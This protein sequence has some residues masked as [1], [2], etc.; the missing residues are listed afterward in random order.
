MK[1]VGEGPVEGDGGGR[2][3][4][5]VGSA[6][7]AGEGSPDGGEAAGR[8]GVP[9]SDS[10]AG[11][12]EPGVAGASGSDSRRA[13]LSRLARMIRLEIVEPAR[14]LPFL[15]CEDYRVIEGYGQV[16][17]EKGLGVRGQGLEEEIQGPSRWWERW[18]TTR[19]SERSACGSDRVV[20][21]EIITAS[22]WW[23]YEGEVVVAGG[24]NSLGRVP[25][26]HIQNSAVPFEYSG[27]SDVELLIPLQDELNTRL[28]DRANRIAMQSFKMYLGK[29]IENFLDQPVG[30]GRMW[31]T[32]NESAEVVEFGG[33]AACPSEDRHI[34][35]LREA[36]DKVSCV[37]PV[38]AGV[39]QGRIGNLTSA[40]ALKITM[41]SLLAKTERKRTTYGAGVEQI[42][43]LALAWLDAAG[44]YRT[45][46][47][48]RRVELHWPSPLPENE[49][50]KLQ[51]A[52]VKVRL[53]V[54]PAVVLR[55]LGY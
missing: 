3:G 51:E 22:R 2:D 9:G 27:A 19:R 34:A 7:P 23:R 55:E 37:S 15:S 41:L 31:M 6:S 46:P 50:E 28:S 26:V 35:E 25:V 12:D 13:R 38:A 45:E 18:F 36:M 17:E 39:I 52:E 4:V 47:E 48:E 43:E 1:G 30:P 21:S 32:E 10:S 8:E 40:V 20:V 11:L 54:E 16:W 49:M 42:C 14:A 33:D 44:V 5:G 53:G 29:G 24:V